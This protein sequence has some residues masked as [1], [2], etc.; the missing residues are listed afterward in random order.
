L[1]SGSFTRREEGQA[2][3][4][5]ALAAVVLMAALALAL[6]SGYGF[7]Q[8]RAMQNAADAGALA[9]ARLIAGNVVTTDRGTVF[10]TYERQ[11]YCAAAAFASD[12]RA[13]R[14]SNPTEDISVQWSATG[15]AGTFVAFSVPSDCG[16][17]AAV[18][19][20]P[21][22]DPTAR[23]ILARP[24]V[25]YRPLVGQAIGQQSTV[26]GATSVARITGAPLP[27]SAPSWPMVRHFNAPDFNAA[28]GSPCN[29]TTV[30]PVTFWDSNDPN[31]VYGDFMG[32]VDLSRFSPNEHRNAGQPPC[33]VSSPGGSASCVPQ[34]LTSWDQTGAAPTG[35][36]DLFGGNACSQAG[37]VSPGAAIG[38]WY[39]NG[40]ENSQSFEKTCS[41]LNWFAYLFGGTLL[42][43]SSWSG[44]TFNGVSEWREQPSALSATR[45]VCAQAASFGLPAPSCAAGSSGLGDWVEAAHTGNVGNN[46][47]TPLQWFIDTFGRT[48]PVYSNMPV[49]SGNGAPLYGKYVVVTV[50]LWDCAETYSSGNAAGSRWA[51]TRPKNGSDCS[52]M[53][54]GNDINSHDAIDRVHLF[55]VAPFTF[56]RGLVSS[57]NIKGFWGGLVSD[58]GTCAADPTA[59]GCAVNQFSNGIFLVPPP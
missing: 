3:V 1:R 53:Q 2:L 41:I 40:N 46:I 56:Y 12:N 16:I 48:D 34:L 14:P 32:L 9:A 39:T 33:T 10:A 36:S 44:V 18:A 35:K 29:P 22:V 43:D 4:V 28:C 5:V 49:S 51:L 55:S 58:P 50:Y 17:A 42:L 21:F 38:R 13:F 31:I 30:S 20:G 7:T 23:F 19:S 24:T 54:Q 6:D 57:N 15:A 27:A 8:R 11:A 25:T 45:A 37:A 52:S 59:P 26:A 47:A